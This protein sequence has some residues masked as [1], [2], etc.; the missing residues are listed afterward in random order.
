MTQ[1]H[2]LTVSHLKKYFPI[3]GGL[4]SRSDRKVYAVD[5]VSFDL[6]KGETLGLV[7][8]SGSGKTTVAWSIL[9]LIE[10]TAGDILFEGKNIAGLSAS[11]LRELR[12]HMQIIFQDPYGC[13]TPRM[14]L[15]NLLKEPLTVHGI[16]S[17]TEKERVA[18]IM[19][20]VGLRPE[21]MDR[22]P[23]EFS[24]GQR[25]RI[26]IARALCCQPQIADR[27]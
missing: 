18:Y 9:R 5:D 23:H 27:G 4:F 8:E 24:G 2:L 15:I 10:P 21:H 26:S 25:Q 3:D 6:R 12:R 14:R 22:F 16:S 17:G 20:K 11:E 13:L 19:E 1:Q 7:G